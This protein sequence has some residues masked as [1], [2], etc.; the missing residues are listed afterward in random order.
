[1]LTLE[2]GLPRGL[3]SYLNN[4]KQIYTMELTHQHCR[5]QFNHEYA[6]SMLKAEGYRL[7]VASNSIRLTIETMMKLARLDGYLETI[8]SNQDVKSGK[9]D[10]EI[11]LNTMAKLGV[12]P[13]ECLILEDNEHGIRAA[14]ASGGHLLVVKDP[15]EVTFD[16][17]RRRIEE[18]EKSAVKA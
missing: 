2:Q 12:Q 17:I 7:A 8:T 15:T 3:H 5:P 10:P 1:M 6:L 18:I 11:Y 13:D 16:R 14:N 4:L 9:P